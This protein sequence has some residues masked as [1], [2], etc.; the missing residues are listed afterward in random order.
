MGFPGVSD[1]KES[2][3]NVE[4]LDSIPGLRRSPGEG[5]GNSLQ[6]SCLE[7]SMDRGAWQAAV[8][9]R[10]V[11]HNSATDA[12]THEL[13]VQSIR[14][15]VAYLESKNANQSTGKLYILVLS[16]SGMYVYIYLIIHI[17]FVSVS[18]I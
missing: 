12:H 2:A 4:D 14:L 11:G 1:S 16:F 9:G 5:N 15:A 3:G 13:I 7:N 10:R 8:W 18:H 6:Y 17:F